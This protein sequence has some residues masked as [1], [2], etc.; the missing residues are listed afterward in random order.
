MV[1]V[2]RR[3]HKRRTSTHRVQLPRNLTT[4]PIGTRCA[5]RSVNFTVGTPLPYAPHPARTPQVEEQGPASQIPRAGRASRLGSKGP[6]RHLPLTP[7]PAGP[8]PRKG[9]ARLGHWGRSLPWGACCYS[10]NSGGAQVLEYSCI[11]VTTS[12]CHWVQSKGNLS[13]FI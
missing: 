4:L 2:H 1:V 11:T 5:L 13:C 3:G 9:L 8:W 6:P 7:R 10:Q 12:H